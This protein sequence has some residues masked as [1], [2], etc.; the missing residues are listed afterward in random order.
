MKLFSKA[1]EYAIRAIMHVIE[2]NS[3]PYFSPKEVCSGADIPEAFARKV[4]G[5]MAKA[6]IIKGTRGPGGG[7]EFVRELSEISLLDIV[8]IVDGENAFVECPM[9]LRCGA[10]SPSEDIQRCSA[11]SLTSPEC[12]LSH[13]CPMHEV[14]KEVRQSVIAHLERTTLQNIKDRLESSHQSVRS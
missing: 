8:T 2:S 6:H 4:L 13:L 9:G 11:C 1:S 3:L 10:K 12:G 14:W 5:A 7:Y